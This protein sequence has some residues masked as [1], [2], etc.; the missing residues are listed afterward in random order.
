MGSTIEAPLFEPYQGRVIIVKSLH[1]SASE[2]LLF[3][4]KGNMQNTEPEKITRDQ[5]IQEQNND[6]SISE[7][8]KLIKAKKLLQ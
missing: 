8:R 2:D 6:A 5:W 3:P 4:S 7:I 1:A